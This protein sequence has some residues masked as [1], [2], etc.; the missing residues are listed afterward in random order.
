MQRR[1]A[2]T[3]WQAVLRLLLAS[4]PGLA[5][6]GGPG[7]QSPVPGADFD[8]YVEDV[9]PVFEA[10]CSERNCHGNDDRPLGLYAPGRHRLDGEQADPDAPLLDDELRANFDRTRAFLAFVATPESCEL[11]TKPLA[12]HAGGVDHGAGAVFTSTIDDEYLDILDW[13]S[14]AVAEES[15]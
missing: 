7:S 8:A 2:S 10:R 13:V 6:V 15:T 5:C 11:L 1:P 9:Q 12:V 4:L 14:D 3:L